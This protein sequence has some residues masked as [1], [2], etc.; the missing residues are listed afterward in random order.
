[1]LFAT[2]A[3]PSCS[4]W[5]S[6]TCA[7]VRPRFAA[8]P[9]TAASSSTPSAPIELDAVRLARLQQP[10]LQQVRVELHGRQRASPALELRQMP[11]RKVAHPYRPQHALTP[12]FAHHLP[13]LAPQPL[14]LRGG[15]PVVTRRVDEVEVDVARAQGRERPPHRRPRSVGAMVGGPELVADG[16]GD[17]CFV[18]VRRG[19]V[20]VPVAG[21]QSLEHARPEAEAVRAIRAVSD[22]WHLGAVVEQYPHAAHRRAWRAEVLRRA[23]QRGCELAADERRHRRRPVCPAVR[24]A[25]LVG[26]ALAVVP[27][28]AAERAAGKSHPRA[29]AAIHKE[30]HAQCPSLASL[31]ELDAVDVLPPRAEDSGAPNGRLDEQPRQRAILVEDKLPAVKVVAAARRGGYGAGRL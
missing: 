31:H 1:M 30:D 25:R 24:V 4:A 3:A 10:Q 16:L 2:T 13:A 20:D 18:R 14:C 26:R 6:V 29:L 19:G 15:P 21:A 27:E 7:G 22:G 28:A 23:S 5:R 11:R 12:Q 8:T 17:D 9:K